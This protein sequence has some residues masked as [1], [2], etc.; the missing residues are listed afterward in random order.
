VAWMDLSDVENPQLLYDNRL[1]VYLGPNE[2]VAYKFALFADVVQRLSAGDRGT[3]RYT[4]GTS[5]T[6]SPD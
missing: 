1:T 4:G 6:Y 3:L 5:W 2:E